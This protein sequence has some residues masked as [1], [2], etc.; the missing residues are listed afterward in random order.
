MKTRPRCWGVGLGRTGTTSLC[1]ALRI[2][3]YNPVR[4]N[5]RFEELASLE[6]GTDNGV[7]VFYK[8]LDYKFPG[9]KFVLTIRDLGDWLPSIKYITDQNPVR[10]LDEDMPIMRRMA[11]YEL[12][13]FDTEKFAAGYLRHHA[14]VRRY[15]AK[16][17]DD[18]LE[19]RIVQ[20]EGWKKLCPHLGL[21]IPSVAFPHSNKRGV[22]PALKLA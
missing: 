15:F 13:T 20:G 5:P 9:S 19:M 17:P 16:R 3:G 2:L 22:A 11:L 14:D 12:V 8:Y 18:L 6:G 7:T 1:D 10:S 4:H 21:P